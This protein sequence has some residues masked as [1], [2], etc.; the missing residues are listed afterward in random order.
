MWLTKLRQTKKDIFMPF[1]VYLLDLFS[2][3]PWDSNKSELRDF[4][5][6]VPLL[7]SPLFLSLTAMQSAI[8][9]LTIKWFFGQSE[10]L[11]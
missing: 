6:I 9:H 3:P 8:F 4:T 1:T 7:S 5:D 2:N 11:S 10:G